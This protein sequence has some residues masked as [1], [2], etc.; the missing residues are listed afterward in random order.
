MKC[1]QKWGAVKC[2]VWGHYRIGATLEKNSKGFGS[3]LFR[4]QPRLC[5]DWML[6]WRGRSW[7]FREKNGLGFGTGKG[8]HYERGLFTGEISRISKICR[9]SRISRKWLDSPLFSK[10]WGFSKIS[11]ISKLSGISRKWTFPKR[12][13]F[14]KTP[15]FPNPRVDSPCADC[16]GFLVPGATGVP[17]PA[18]HQGASEWVL[19]RAFA[20]RALI[21][22]KLRTWEIA[23]KA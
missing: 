13:L 3:E 9:F 12:P 17:P 22:G 15:F 8:G 20:F 10:L 2:I 16:P 4:A 19:E 23:R 14:Q 5:C 11:R 1:L 7:N 18:L 6:Q 21:V